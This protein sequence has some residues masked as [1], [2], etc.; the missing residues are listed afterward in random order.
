MNDKLR[1]QVIEILSRDKVKGE[2]MLNEF[3]WIN[4][5]EPKFS[6]EAPVAFSDARVWIH[7][8]V[9]LDGQWEQ[10]RRPVRN[11]VGRV[12]DVTAQPSARTF[13]YAVEYEV[14]LEE[15]VI[16]GQKITHHM[17]YLM[18]YEMSTAQEYKLN[19]WSEL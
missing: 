2:K 6:I 5:T 16:N 13:S 8:G 18:E 12:L 14:D 17:A 3:V 7:R 9:Y 10:E 1:A 15:G 19:K 4:T 11:C